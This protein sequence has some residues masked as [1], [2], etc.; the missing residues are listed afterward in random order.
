MFEFKLTHYRWLPTQRTRR[1]TDGI[2]GD[3]RPR[4]GFGFEE[5]TGFGEGEQAA[6]D[7]ELELTGVVRHGDD[8][9]DGVAAVAELLDDEI[10]VD[11]VLHGRPLKRRDAACA[12]RDG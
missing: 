11:G 12:R 5:G 2:Q 1:D 6:V 4:S 9:A 10:G 3:S 7:L 8:V